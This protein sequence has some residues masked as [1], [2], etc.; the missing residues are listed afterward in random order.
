MLDE[1]ELIERVSPKGD[2]KTEAEE[3]FGADLELVAELFGV[4]DGSFDFGVADFAFFG[5]DVEAGFELGDFLAEVFHDD[6]GFDGVDIHGDVENLIDVDKGRDPA[7]IEG[8][9]VAVDVD[10][11]TVFGAEAEIAGVEL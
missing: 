6:G 11:A 10:G 1:A 2:I 4:A 3:L 7:G 5:I 8:T 9:G